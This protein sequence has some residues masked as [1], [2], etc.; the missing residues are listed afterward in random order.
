MIPIND[1]DGYYKLHNHDTSRIEKGNTLIVF[2]NSGFF[3]C[4]SIRLF[5]I[6]RYYYT[7]DY[8]LPKSVD[9]SQQ[10][11]W[12]KN[13]SDN[14]DITYTYF[15]DYNNI[16]IDKN[17]FPKTFM[18][19]HWDLQ[20]TPYQNIQFNLITPFIE[21]YFTPSEEILRIVNEI[22][23][24]YGIDYDRTCVLYYRG[25]DKSTETHICRHEDL[26]GKASQEIPSDVIFLIQS[27]ESD[28]IHKALSAYPNNSFVLE[29]Y[30]RHIKK[31]VKISVDMTQRNLNNLYSKYY[32][33]ITIIMSRCKYIVCTSG[34]CSIWIMYYRQNANNII[35]YLNHEWFNTII[36]PKRPL[37]QSN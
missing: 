6:I 3:S 13:K 36:K 35:Q 10:F 14:T 20:F 8:T 30:I 37:K 18:K 29:K 34:N 32:L 7:H 25:N 28:F 16:E 26:I 22:E 2:H 4:C 17:R 9:S 23:N 24:Q 19:H 15:E 11:S 33:A 1:D 31:N 27:D 5:H 12:Y 21:K